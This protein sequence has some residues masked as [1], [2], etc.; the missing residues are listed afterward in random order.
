MRKPVV[1]VPRVSL[2]CLRFMICCHYICFPHIANN[3]DSTLQ[4]IISGIPSRLVLH[5]EH[6]S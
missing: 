5:R 2:H 1:L 6:E 4:Y 3:T